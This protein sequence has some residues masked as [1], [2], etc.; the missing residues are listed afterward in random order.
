M[1]KG[2]VRAGWKPKVLHSC[3]QKVRH[4]TQAAA[5]QAISEVGDPGSAYACPFCD[6]WHWGGSRT[7]AEWPEH[8]VRSWRQWAQLQRRVR[9]AT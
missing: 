9:G 4:E 3:V 5:E 8:V 1:S 2:M 6:G 7:H